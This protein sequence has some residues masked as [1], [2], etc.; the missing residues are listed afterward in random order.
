[1]WH[2]QVYTK[3]PAKVIKTPPPFVID[4]LSPKSNIPNPTVR[5]CFT[6]PAM[7]I[8]EMVN[9][10]GFYGLVVIVVLFV[11]V[12]CCLVCRLLFVVVCCC[13]FVVCWVPPNPRTW[14]RNSESW[15]SHYLFININQII[16]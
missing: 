2:A 12:C 1:M 15:T 5:T 7:D 11:V 3:T 6:F 10:V 8:F 16:K 9:R 14:T 13:L 4:N